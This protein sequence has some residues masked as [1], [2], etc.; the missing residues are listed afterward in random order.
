MPT[1]RDVKQHVLYRFARAAP[2]NDMRVAALK[3]IPF[4]GHVG[5]D[6]GIG[7]SLTIT[8]FKDPGRELLFIDDRARLTPDVTLLCSTVP[9]E[10]E[11]GEIYGTQEP[12]RI[13]KDAWI[14]AGS[15]LLAGVTIG[16]KAVVA[17]GS[18]VTEDVEPETIVG[19]V[20][21]KKIKDVEWN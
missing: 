19:G 13:G 12:I 11:L 3:R 1:L 18:V 16:E 20:P 10:S 9:H 14:G 2:T 5:E 17:A 4:V 21:A 7:P 15:I 6:V 8:P